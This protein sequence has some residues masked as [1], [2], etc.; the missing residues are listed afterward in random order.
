ME[1]AFD[2][3]LFRFALRSRETAAASEIKPVA[4][5]LEGAGGGAFGELAEAF[6]AVIASSLLFLRSVKRVEV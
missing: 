6:R 2:G 1:R 4:P 5:S 3:T